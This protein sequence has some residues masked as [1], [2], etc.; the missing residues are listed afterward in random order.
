MVRV[1]GKIKHQDE[2]LE[3]DVELDV[4]GITQDDMPIEESTRLIINAINEKY[5]VNFPFSS[6]LNPVIIKK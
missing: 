2:T 5:S 4:D 1:E 6:F 3:Y